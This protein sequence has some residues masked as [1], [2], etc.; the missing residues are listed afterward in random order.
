[1]TAPRVTRRSPRTR[2][3]LLDG[4]ILFFLLFMAIL[5][6]FPVL[7]VLGISFAS[8][9][10]AA[11]NPLLLIPTKPTIDNYYRLFQDPR[12]V[13]GYKTTLLI[14]LLGVPINMFLT[15]SLA[16]GLSR[17]NFPGGKLLFYAVL[18]TM[19]FNG[20]IVP[21]YLLMLQIR[22]TRTL[23]SVILA[24][25]VNTFYLIIT[26][27][28]MTTLPESLIESAKM[29]GAGEMRILFR[30]ILPLSKPIVATVLLFY[31]VDRWNEWF[32]AMLFLRRN[33]L[34]PLQLVLR[35]IVMDSVI[36]N[37]LSIA[38]PR[39]PRFTEGI[40]T[41]TIMVTMLPV[42]CL[43]PFLQKYFVKGIMIGAI[44]A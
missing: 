4:I 19:L 3:E 32:N 40:Q 10:E 8:Q 43:F 30:I 26:R 15:T 33:D 28:Y 29:D 16:F 5:I 39:I 7:N 11:E 27:T 14:L 2:F 9:K 13:I 37:S 36:V 12:I 20:G 44:K 22:L 1:M 35:T 17:T 24:Y 38:G 6:V 31:A 18:L 34:I 42:M 25:G 23:W 41:A 21:L